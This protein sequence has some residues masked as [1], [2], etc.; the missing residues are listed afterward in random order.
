MT[1]K[2]QILGPVPAG[3]SDVFTDVIDMR[4]GPYSSVRFHATFG[5]LWGDVIA[6]VVVQESPD[7]E[8]WAD[9]PAANREDSDTAG[10]RVIHTDAVHPTGPYV[11]GVVVRKQHQ[12]SITCIHAEL[13]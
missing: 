2:L 10:H 8:T 6:P 1:I 4:T 12:A 7:G 13:S 9:L 5:S 11:R 3:K